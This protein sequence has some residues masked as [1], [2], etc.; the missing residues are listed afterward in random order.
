MQ[1]TLRLLSVFLFLSLQITAQKGR[2]LDQPMI[3]NNCS[4]NIKVNCIHAVTDV[5]LE[6]Y[7]DRDTEIEGLFSF[8]LKPQQAITGF[9]LDLNGKYRKGTIEERWK[10]RNAYNTI[11]GKRV[12]PALLQMVNTNSFTLNIYPVP[13][14]SSRK[15]K[16]RIEEVLPLK[17]GYQQYLFEMFKQTTL[18]QVSIHIETMGTPYAP[19]MPEGLINRTTFNTTNGGH[20]LNDQYTQPVSGGFIGFKIPS[21]NQTETGYIDKT[22]GNFA[23]K[24]RDTLPETVTRSIKKIRVYWDRSGSMRDENDD[25]FTKFLL[26]QVQRYNAESVEI[27]PFNH[28]RG[29]GRLFTG[30][31]MQPNAWK[32]FI[33]SI[34]LYGAT[35]FGAL[36]FETA[37]DIIFVFTD[38]KHSWGSRYNDSWQTPVLF[39]TTPYYDPLYKHSYYSA[40]YY[41]YNYDYYYNN[42]NGYKQTIRLNTTDTNYY[43]PQIAQQK[44]NLVNAVDE[45][46]KPVKLEMLEKVNG[47]RIVS[48]KLP[49]NS[50]TIILNFGYG[51]HILYTREINEFTSC[52]TISN[53]RMGILFQY[54][55]I[56]GNTNNWYQSLAFGIE[57]KIVA[58]QT[59]F[60]VLERIEDYVKF[61]IAPPDEIL[62]ECV[63]MGY[64]KQ[65]YKLRYQ[66]MQKANDAEML[67]LVAAE[68]NKRIQ[69]W[70]QPASQIKLA[71]ISGSFARVEEE[72]KTAERQQLAAMEKT[73]GSPASPAG[74]QLSE[75]VVTAGYSMRSRRDLSYSV[76]RVS[77][78][79]LMSSTTLSQALQGKV[80]GVQIINAPA[81]ND[82]SHIRIRGINSLSYGGNPLLIVDGLPVSFDMINQF[83]PSEIDNIAIIKNAE[84]AA[85]YGSRGTN[86]A[87]VVQTKRGRNNGYRDYTQKTRLKDSDDE[88]YLMDIKLVTKEEKFSRYLQLK[89]D[90]KSNMAF[91]LDMAMHFSDAGITEPIEEMLLEAA[92]LSNN[93][94]ASLLAIAYTC[95]YMRNYK[96]AAEVYADLAKSFPQQ[97]NLF[98]NMAW[99]YYQAGE[100]DSAVQIL[101]RSIAKEDYTW[102]VQ[103][104]KMK[105]MM[106]ADMNMMITLNP[107]K[108][109]TRYIPAEI[110]KPVTAE[111]RV[112]LDANGNNLYTLTAQEGNDAK[113]SVSLPVSGNKNMSLYSNY[114]TTAELQAKQLGSKRIR[115]TVNHYDTWYDNHVPPMIRILVVRNFGTP[116]QRVH[117]EIVSL[118]N[119]FGEVEI[120]DFRK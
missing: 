43:Y 16:I 88:D 11:V 106:L 51:K 115:L 93:D 21:P 45:Y 57:N 82:I 84:A 15:V 10:A 104:I 110:I 83:V 98:H 7:N 71:D 47:T 77:A 29:T 30:N 2:L 3:I 48:G 111:L 55:Q 20:I 37:D 70:N 68:Y 96:K 92:E 74:S 117:T 113:L 18:K 75:V 85:I 64:V 5:E 86:G 99:A 13:S 27:I 103:N 39:V 46:G 33:R 60:I 107:N 116:D 89:E 69:L 78:N 25:D 90:N 97:L 40:D 9:E 108:T 118:K 56:T 41:Y 81:S 114:Y 31:E 49:L 100:P 87:I 8:T 44:I 61:N 80:P 65:D 73:F 19:V 66:Q 109:D 119:Q 12:D 38:G 34:P 53:E 17:D 24:F 58:W 63:N 76:S 94:Y 112:L 36:D 54:E 22:T 101:Y 59:A 32:K 6:F 14:K 105:E 23:F 42:Y 95:E 4:I 62:Q 50:K 52:S 35:N 26:R 91:F 102:N 28:K 67:K 120:A 79:Q 72:K 1:K